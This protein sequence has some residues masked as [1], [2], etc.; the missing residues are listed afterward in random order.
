MLGLIIILLSYI[1][2]IRQ[3]RDKRIFQ[4]INLYYCFVS[5]DW[6]INKNVHI[7]RSWKSIMWTRKPISKEYELWILRML[8]YEIVK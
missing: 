1:N 7:I 8:V 2:E 3:R 4:P 6:P 5:L